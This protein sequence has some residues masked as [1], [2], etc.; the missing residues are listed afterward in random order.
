MLDLWEASPE[1]EGARAC[2]GLSVP[3]SP[4]CSTC[5]SS[6][7]IFFLETSLHFGS[8]GRGTI[9]PT[10]GQMC[11]RPGFSV[12]LTSLPVSTPPPKIQQDASM[13][14]TAQSFSHTHLCSSS[15]FF[16]WSPSGPAERPMVA[17]QGAPGA[18]LAES[19]ACPFP[20]SSIEF[21]FFR[22]FRMP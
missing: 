4:A 7:C 19:P 13:H 12:G 18:L 11:G 6:S 15:H 22:S 2:H 10:T 20:N 8:L 14:S 21:S 5:L 3:C 16:S 9:G 17:F 1:Q